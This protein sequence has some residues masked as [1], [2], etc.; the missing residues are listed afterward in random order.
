MGLS[1]DIFFRQYCPM[2]LAQYQ[3]AVT[4]KDMVE[5]FSFVDF[6]EV[7]FELIIFLALWCL[8]L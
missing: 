3:N 5:S 8:L 6:I 4:R 1:N 2:L 7:N